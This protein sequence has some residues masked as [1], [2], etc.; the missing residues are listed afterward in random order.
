MSGRAGRRESRAQG[1]PC[2]GM[3]HEDKAAPTPHRPLTPAWGVTWLLLA[4]ALS[5]VL[6]DVLLLVF[7]AVLLALIL[8][9]LARPL[10]R[11]W[12]ARAAL[13]SVVVGAALALVLGF[14]LAGASA[15]EELQT[16]RETL[17]RS[18]DALREWLGTHAIGRWLIELA[19]S[20]RAV[21]ETWSAR[22]AGWATGTLNA[23]FSALGAVVLIVALGIY[24]AADAKTYRNGLVRLVPPRHRSLAVQT[25]DALGEDLTRWLKGQGVSMLAVGVLTAIGLS[26]IG[27]PLV[28]TLSA[29]ATVLDFV[30]YFGPIAAG[31]LIVAVAFTEGEQQALYAALVCLA[32][33]QAEAYLV[34]PIAQRWAVRLAPA[35]SLLSVLVFGLLFGLPGVLLAVPLMVMLQT[36]VQRVYV[37][38]VLEAASGDDEDRQHQ[39]PR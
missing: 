10:E 5:W 38:A 25:L 20:A 28:F 27:M 15:V 2:R 8:R 19:A 16:L 4:L 6:A 3:P 18:W 29:L 26:L 30:P 24:F 31:V 12:P 7:A 9:L 17:P 23:T 1:V 11:R 22:L 36:L 33:Q 21:P 39:A 34:Q 13:A 37:G 32:V 14:W 35:L